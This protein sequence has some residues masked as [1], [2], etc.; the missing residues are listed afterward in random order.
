MACVDGIAFRIPEAAAAGAPPPP[1]VISPRQVP[2]SLLPLSQRYPLP[3]LL[4]AA[5]FAS[6]PPE[7]SSSSR[8]PVAL[9][10]AAAG[11]AAAA[12]A[13]AA[14]GAAAGAGPH[15]SGVLRSQDQRMA[16]SVGLMVGGGS[17]SQ[18]LLPYSIDGTS[19]LQSTE[20]VGG[21]RLQSQTSSVTPSMQQ[22]QLGYVGGGQDIGWG[23]RFRV[24]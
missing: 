1:R 13:T 22:Q 15:S 17:N 14:A 24:H 20:A 7:N 19:S 11:T 10:A 2:A 16:C 8:V 23:C 5:L 6:P 18:L 4:S 12:A 9:I 21:R 3:A